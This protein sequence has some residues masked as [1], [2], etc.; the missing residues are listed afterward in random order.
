MQ[1]WHNKVDSLCIVTNDLRHGK[2][3]FKILFILELN[4]I[5]VNDSKIEC[6]HNVNLFENLCGFLSNFSPS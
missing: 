6:T 2:I 4:D 1:K 3:Y 5:P